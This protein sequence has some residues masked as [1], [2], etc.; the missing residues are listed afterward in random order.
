[1]NQITEDLLKIVSDWNGIPDAAYKPL[2]GDDKDTAK[3]YLQANRAA[4]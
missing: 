4:T 1:M 3:Y 2:T